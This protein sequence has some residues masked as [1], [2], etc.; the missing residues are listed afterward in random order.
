MALESQYSLF[1]IGF[2]NVAFR[3]GNWGKVCGQTAW[4]TWGAKESSEIVGVVR[5][6]EVV[7]IRYDLTY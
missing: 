4:P 3:S 7:S 6:G 2:S 1:G 5:V